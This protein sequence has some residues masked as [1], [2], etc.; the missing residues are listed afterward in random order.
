MTYRPLLFVFVD[1]RF[2]LSNLELISDI[3]KIIKLVEILDNQNYCVI[4]NQF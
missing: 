2:E 3:D 1:K 4:G